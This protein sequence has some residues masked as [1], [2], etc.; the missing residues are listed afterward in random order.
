MLWE[1][2]Q[3][4]SPH[5]GT[6]SPRIVEKSGQFRK[7][8]LPGLVPHLARF[9]GVCHPLAICQIIPGFGP[10]PHAP[11]VPPRRNRP[12]S[13]RPEEA[14]SL[15]KYRLRGPSFGG[16]ALSVAG[17]RPTVGHVPD[18][19]FKPHLPV[20]PGRRPGGFSGPACRL[21]P[22]PRGC[23]RMW[24]WRILPEIG[25]TFLLPG[26]GGTSGGRVGDPALLLC[27]RLPWPGNR[28]GSPAV[29]RTGI[30]CVR[31]RG[32]DG[33]AANRSP[34]PFR[35]LVRNREGI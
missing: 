27:I 31:F 15:D 33:P 28:P 20:G 22:V 30:L 13:P 14:I 35:P 9:S 3:R 2:Q 5:F 8:G 24:L 10:V 17:Q 23:R 34:P 11:Q 12:C 26:R 4:C 32:R 19:E 29:S 16:S 18:P 1:W 21:W 25:S 6:E 7:S